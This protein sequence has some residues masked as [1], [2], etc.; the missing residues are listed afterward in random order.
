MERAPRAS[1]KQNLFREDLKEQRE[2]R[3]TTDLPG[4]VRARHGGR[5]LRREGHRCSREQETFGA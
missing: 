4:N 2:R 1:Q 3:A 5:Q